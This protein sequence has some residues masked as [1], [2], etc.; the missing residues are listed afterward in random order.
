MYVCVYVRMYL[1]MLLAE[2]GEVK[3]VL[4]IHL[5]CKAYFYFLKMGR[6]KT[7]DECFFRWALIVHPKNPL[8]MLNYALMQQGVYHNYDKA[9]AYYRYY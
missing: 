5:F 1:R 4:L 9:E 2:I 7:A 8:A 3:D 6:F